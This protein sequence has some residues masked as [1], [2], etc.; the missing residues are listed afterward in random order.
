M[1][2]QKLERVLRR[3]RAENPGRKKISR[4][5]LQKAIMKEIGID[6]RTYRQNREA[7]ISLGWLRSHKGNAFW[8]TDKDITDS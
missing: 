1:S 4:P 8:L 6:P 2:I 3:I 5:I 7:L